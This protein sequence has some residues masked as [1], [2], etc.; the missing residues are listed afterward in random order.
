MKILYNGIDVYMIASRLMT[1]KALSGEM[2]S[3]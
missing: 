2:L 1:R 3:Q